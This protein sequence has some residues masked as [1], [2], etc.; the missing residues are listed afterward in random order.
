MQLTSEG[1][2]EEINVSGQDIESWEKGESQ[3]NLKQLEA[4][5]ELFGREIDYFLRE[6]P[7]PPEKIEFRGRPGKTLGALPI[8][9]RMVLAR[10]DEFCRTAIEFE[11][12]LGE[13]LQSRLRKFKGSVPPKEVAQILRKELNLGDKPLHNLREDLESTGVRIYELPIP[14]EAFSGFSFWH[15]Q[16]GPC[17]LINAREP[18][19]RRNFTLAHELAHLLYQD[20]P[21]LC[22]ITFKAG[23]SSRSLEAKANQFAIELL[24]PEV[25]AKQDFNQRKIP[26]TPSERELAQ[27]ASKWVVSIQ[28]LGYRLENLGL[29][30]TGLTD[31]IRESKPEYFRT[32]RIPKWKRQLGK[33][34]VE[35]SIQAY[36]KN[37]ISVGK[38]AHAFQIP[39]RKAI[40]IV[41]SVN[42]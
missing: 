16:Y 42:K 30:E 24:L 27:M 26:R 17:I 5:A 36:N 22:Y 12:L 23:D 13:K 40:K 35:I 33:R 21:S 31:Q 4:L 1:I 39:I 10:F 6:T 38:L 25:A 34:F 11:D 18:K 19:G 7:S 37:L 41:E 15:S 8:E 9:A 3:P 28:A 29:I 14:E 32:P 2:A 20:S